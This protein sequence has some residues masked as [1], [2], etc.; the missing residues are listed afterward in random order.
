MPPLL[1][2]FSYVTDKNVNNDLIEIYPRKGALLDRGIEAPV[3][4]E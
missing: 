4:D 3:H 1:Q 2:G